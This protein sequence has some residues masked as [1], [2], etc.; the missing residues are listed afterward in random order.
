M[1]EIVTIVNL[2]RLGLVIVWMNIC[3]MNTDQYSQCFISVDFMIFSE[4]KQGA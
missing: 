3:I 1:K 2:E 4:E